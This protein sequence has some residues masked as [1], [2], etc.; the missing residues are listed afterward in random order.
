[1]RTTYKGAWV[2]KGEG[3]LIARKRSGLKPTILSGVTRDP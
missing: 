2:W 1:M 3:F